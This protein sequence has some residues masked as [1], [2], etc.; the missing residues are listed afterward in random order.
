MNSSSVDWGLGV[1]VSVY[2]GPMWVL[3]VLVCLSG[4]PAVSGSFPSR[5]S[6]PPAGHEKDSSRQEAVSAWR[7]DGALV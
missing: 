4:V 1:C 3:R 7:R 6:V 5:D 2:P